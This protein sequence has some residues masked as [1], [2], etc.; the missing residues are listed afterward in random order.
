MHTHTYQEHWCRGFQLQKGTRKAV[1]TIQGVLEKVL[2]QIRQES[3]ETL[4]MQCSGRTD[5]GVHAKGQ[6]R[7]QECICHC[8]IF[9]FLWVGEQLFQK[10]STV[11]NA[12]W[13]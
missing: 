12:F 1:P 7:L 10:H 9:A 8:I 6:V 5:A 13:L 2:C 4:R 11:L 3:R